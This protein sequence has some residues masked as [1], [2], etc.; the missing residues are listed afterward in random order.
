MTVSTTVYNAGLAPAP[1]GTAHLFASLLD[2]GGTALPLNQ[3]GA[4]EV[5]LPL[6]QNPPALPALTGLSLP[7]AQVSYLLPLPAGVIGFLLQGFDIRFR[8][9]VGNG[10]GDLHPE[11]DSASSTFGW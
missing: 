3:T 11:N 6:A 10:S 7:K 9:Q 8:F 4:T 2:P 1:A 5:E